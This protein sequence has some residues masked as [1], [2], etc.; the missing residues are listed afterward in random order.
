LM[1]PGKH[2]WNIHMLKI[3][4][5]YSRDVEEVRKIRLSEKVEEDALAWYYKKNSIFTGVLYKRRW[6]PID[7]HGARMRAKRRK[8]TQAGLVPA[9][10]GE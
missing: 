8:A 9:R 6:L 2:E 3:T 10:P 5:L 4:R 1:I 7:E